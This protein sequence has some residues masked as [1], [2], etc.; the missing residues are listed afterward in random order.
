VQR[1]C[2]AGFADC[3]N[4]VS[5]GCE[6]RLATDASNCGTCGTTCAGANA[7]GVCDHGQC[8]LLCGQG[9]SDCDGDPSNGCETTGP[10]GSPS[11]SFSGPTSVAVGDLA[12]YTATADDPV[13]GRTL[14]YAWTAVSGPGTVTFATPSE[15]TTTADFLAP[16]T[17]VVQFEA[18][19]GFTTT[20]ADLTVTAAYVNKPP[21]VVVGADQTL[22]ASTLTTTLSGNATD[23]GLPLGATLRGTWSMISG[24]VAPTIATP[25]T[26][27][28]E[29]GPLTASTSVTFAYPGTYVFALDVT[30]TSLAG[31]GTTTVTVN[32]PAASG[33]GGGGGASAPTVA[34]GG[35]T[36]DQEVTKPTPILGTVSDGAWV[37][38][39]RLGGRDDVDAAWT[40][41]AS[42]TGPVSGTSIATFDPTLLLNGIYTVRLSAT[43]S[44]GSA[45]ANVSLS[46]DGR[47]KV[48]DFT[49]AFTDLATAV[50]NLPFTITRDYDSRDKSVGDFGVGWKLGLTDVRVEKSGKTGAYWQQQFTDEGVFAQFCLLPSQASSVAITF[51]N[52]RQYRFAP[53]SSPQ[54]ALNQELTA[55]DITWVSTSDPDNPTITL[56]A[57][58]ETSVFA[59][60]VGNGVTQLQTD[61]GDIWDPRQ[62]T[63]TIEDGSVYQIDQDK[64]VTQVTDRNG[65]TITITPDGILHSSGT[66]VTFARDGK[67]RI[68]TI[69]DPA[70]QPMTYA[71]DD[72]G[73]LAS[74]TDRA[75]NVTQFGYATN[76]YLDTIQDPL[77]RRPI[78]NDYDA[79][80]R[81]LSTTD[82]SGN[83][84]HYTPN[85]AANQEQIADRLGHVTLYTYNDRGDVTQKVDATGA[86]WNYT[87]D[88]RG[89]PLTQTDPLGN[90]KTTTYDGADDP[91]TQTDALGAV[92]TSTYNAYRQLL[93]T[94]D[95]L[96]H[97]TTNAYDAL[98]NLA[99]TTDPIGNTT[100]YTYD[101]SGNQ[102]TSMDALG[103]VTNY[104]YDGAGHVLQTTDALGNTTS[105]TYDANGNTTSESANRTNYDGTG[106]L[107]VTTY[108]YD[109]LGHVT[110]TAHE[111]AG[112][113][114]TTYTATGKRATSTDELGR[115]TKYA[116]DVL[117]RLMTTARP[118]GTSTS[119]TYDAENHRLS[120]TDAAGNATRYA[121]DPVGRLL[122]TTYADNAT[123]ST[124]YDGAGNAVQ[125]VD[126]LGHV[127]WT[128]YDA[129]AHVTS[130]TDPLGEVTLQTYDAA[131][132]QV[133]AVDPLGHTTTYAYDANNR[134][135]AT[136]YADGSASSTRYD[137]LGRATS[138]IDELGRTVD[139][140]YDALGRLV[141]VTDALGDVTQY[142]YNQEGDRLSQADANKRTTSFPIDTYTGRPI[143]RI[144]PDGSSESR[145]YDAAGEVTT[146]TDFEGRTTSYA[147]DLAG[148]VVSRTYPDSTGVSFTYTPD[149]LRA[150]ATDARGTTT[151][152]YDMRRRLTKLTY[153]DGRSLAYGYDAHGDRTS[154]TAK[155]GSQTLATTTG[156][157]AAGRPSRVQDPLARTTTVAYDAAGN[158]TA[159]AYP[160]A[161][162]TTYAYDP[163]NRLLH[164]ATQTTGSSPV[165]IQSYAYTL[166]LAGRRTEVSEADGTL[167]G[168]GY[169]SIDRLTGETVSGSLTYSKT[170][171]YD[172]VGNRLTQT[173]TGAGAA[174][175]N[176]A[177]DERDRLTTENATDYAYDTD[178][179]VTSKSGEA[180]YGWDFENRLTSVHMTGGA[181]VAHQYDVDGNRVQTTMTPSGGSAATTDLLV[182][183]RGSLSQVIAETDGGASLGAYYVRLGDELLEVM[184]PAAAGTWTTKFIHGDG[185]GS[186]RTLTDETGTTVDSRS[187]EAF[188]TRNSEA[189]SDPLTY[190]FAGEPFDGTSRLECHR[191]RWMDPTVGR[192]TGM[193]PFDGNERVPATLH[194]YAYVM[195]DPTGPTDPSGLDADFGGDLSFSGLFT[196]IVGTVRALGGITV[197]GRFA[198]RPDT[199]SKGAPPAGSCGDADG[200][201]TVF[202]RWRANTSGPLHMTVIV[203]SLQTAYF[204]GYGP[205]SSNALNGTLGAHENA[206]KQFAR[207]WWNNQNM[208][209]IALT[210]QM[211][212]D[213]PDN[214][215]QAT[216]IDDFLADLHSAEQEH[217]VDNI[218]T[219]WPTFSG[220]RY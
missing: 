191:A 145:A 168:Y 180:T 206:H 78:R 71:Y 212:F 70:G 161:T 1:A 30:D 128:A 21:A 143:G 136:I 216:A 179:N 100:H 41:M 43:N 213:V 205:N 3:N 209:A 122:R 107:A 98:G 55:P 36:D 65:N 111:N 29:P 94:K 75:G 69:T 95:P 165:T 96:G 171:Q 150:T 147:Y 169:D 66:Q 210:E 183:T 166:D 46:V 22:A 72:D 53:Q 91:L 25:T 125:T 159:M 8:A 79:D 67:G 86:V 220:I 217:A 173:T 102:L 200:C 110:Q 18:N 123:A 113:T 56:V 108:Q 164:E 142:T 87:F 13:P 39:S 26:S 193:D 178:G 14:T 182:D 130:M 148:R 54:C 194:R 92:T 154:L 97:V 218:Q 184:R 149:G 16:G 24:P 83:T 101:A 10:C 118:D 170:F 112:T 116:Y 12:E 37:L 90:T 163:R 20:A 50:G 106:F 62:F 64:G 158:R 132:N 32:A 7:T 103:F 105:D 93:T 208:D 172:A 31:N 185:L 211:S 76:H 190:A 117:D 42:G 198:D 151:Y 201:T 73:D 61:M 27:V 152:G 2:T 23:D 85:L 192:F 214:L 177:Y 215:T 153:P 5:D 181:T 58:D 115:V 6:V 48:G 146:R 175:V 60:D 121:Y 74:Y 109:A 188:G 189:G 207:D 167:R 104:Q 133:S 202:T 47:M 38:E 59:N 82:A 134:A 197:S 127:R 139:F 34:I 88:I 35:V 187:Y 51:P 126:E 89:N 137:A 11:V 124:V 204:N 52:G 195:N 219:P 40:V 186:V 77:G 28:V 68:T 84:V 19:D 157:D 144:L 9:F 203:D 33:G 196:N 63:L 57:A 199:F 140:A 138:T 162:N 119:Q 135:V 81:L 44:A 45:Q 99:S 80:G 15:L 160:N 131:G 120:S 156:Y 129:D 17:Y 114:S 174:T 49:L 4:D 176:Y 141:Q 155:I